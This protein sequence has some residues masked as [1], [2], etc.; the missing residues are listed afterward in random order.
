[1]KILNEI[2]KND[3]CIFREILAC[4]VVFDPWERPYY[5]S[6]L[7]TSLAVAY[8][9]FFVILRSTFSELEAKHPNVWLTMDILAD[10]MYLG[11]MVVQ[12]RKGTDKKILL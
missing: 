4:M 8:N 10:L 11:D 9:L 3:F 7:L 2:K 1:M 12:A 6:L 5:I